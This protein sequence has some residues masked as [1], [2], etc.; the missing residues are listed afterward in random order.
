MSY[1]FSTP[2]AAGTNLQ[3]SSLWDV[4]IA[5]VNERLA[6]AGNNG[7]QSLGYGG[8]AVP[9]PPV[10]AVDPATGAWITSVTSGVDIQLSSWWV[11]PQ[12][13]GARGMQYAISSMIANQLF[14]DHRI[15]YEGNSSNLFFNPAVAGNGLAVWTMPNLRSAAGLPTTNNGNA[16]WR[17]K[18]PREINT[19]HDTT[20]YQGNPAIDGQRAFLGSPSSNTWGGGFP[21]YM[22]TSGQLYKYDGASAT[23]KLEYTG[24]ADILDNT[25]ASPDT[26][27]QQTGTGADPFGFFVAGDLI[28]DHLFEEVRQVVNLLRWTW[29]GHGGP[30]FVAVGADITES[31]AHQS[32]AVGTSWTSFV[33]YADAVSQF[34]AGWPGTSH[35]AF[36]FPFAFALVSDQNNGLGQEW[37]I[38]ANH[39]D[40]TWNLPGLPAISKEID[41][42][43]YGDV[44]AASNMSN[45]YDTQGDPVGTS[46]GY[47]IWATN[48]GT[49]ATSV[50]S[51]QFG[52]ANT[53]PPDVPADPG[54]GNNAAKGYQVTDFVAICKYT[55]TYTF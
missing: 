27:T 12:A 23:W 49:S 30:T 11:G 45:T 53:A 47:H 41:W 43:V 51:P 46:P 13:T 54:L 10:A 24:T 33:S 6:A 21:G 22:G 52:N 37:I 4:L 1:S 44:T 26:I 17:R 35:S 20:D 9:A 2:V 38:S 40:A 29:Y 14:C 25:L 8:F 48:A 32:D 28:E 7:L 36:N 16:N 5:A 19:I 3:D 50:T 15:S 55:F 18:R 34:N 42:L 31:A 39:Q